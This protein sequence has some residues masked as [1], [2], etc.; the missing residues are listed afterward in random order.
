MHLFAVGM[1]P[2]F[3]H[4]PGTHKRGGGK[5]GEIVPSMPSPHKIDWKWMFKD[6]TLK[7]ELLSF[8]FHGASDTW[9]GNICF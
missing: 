7:K 2:L 5:V 9:G 8:V 6:E 3:L 1:G 4:P